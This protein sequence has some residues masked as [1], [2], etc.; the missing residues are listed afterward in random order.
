[1][2]LRVCEFSHPKPTQNEGFQIYSV[3]S[4]GKQKSAK[5]CDLGQT[6]EFRNVRLGLG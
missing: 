2:K 3:F 6:F 5:R 1:M 4:E